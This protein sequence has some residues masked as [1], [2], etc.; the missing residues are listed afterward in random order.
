MPVASS[1]ECHAL[2]LALEGDSYLRKNFYDNE[3][4]ELKFAAVSV[5]EVAR[6]LINENEQLRRR[7]SL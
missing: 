4:R 3:L 6:M 2:A 7:H 1:T 5:S